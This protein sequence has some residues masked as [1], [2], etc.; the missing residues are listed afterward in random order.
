MAKSKTTAK[1]KA[2]KRAAKPTKAEKV[3]PSDGVQLLLGNIMEQKDREYYT[4]TF[5]ALK[6]KADTATAHVRDFRKKAKEAGVNMQ[7]LTDTLSMER[8]DPLEV[9]DYLKQQM[10]FFRDRGMPVQISLYEPKFESI[11]KQATQMGWDAGKNGRSPPVDLFPEGAPGHTEM[12][13]AWNDAQKEIIES[14][15]KGKQPA[16]MFEE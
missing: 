1:P 10:M 5:L 11:E 8:L 9:A 13:R 15:Q 2:Q 4:M 14:G 12:M 16:P 3:Q 7:A 6:A